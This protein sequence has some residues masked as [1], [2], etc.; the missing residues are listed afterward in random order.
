MVQYATHDSVL[1][2]LKCDLI[3]RLAKDGEEEG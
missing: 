3:F 2:G 1:R